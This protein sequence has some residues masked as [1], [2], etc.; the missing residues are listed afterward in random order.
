MLRVG[1]LP[2]VSDLVPRDPDLAHAVRLLASRHHAVLLANH[3]PVVADT[4]LN[5][6]QYTVEELEEAPKIF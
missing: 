1:G 4:S 2:S 6:A 5:N 3:G